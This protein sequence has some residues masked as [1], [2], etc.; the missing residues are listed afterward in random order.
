MG[1]VQNPNYH[2]TQ[3]TKLQ[4]LHEDIGYLYNALIWGK[5]DEEGERYRTISRER[6][7][8][9]SKKILPPQVLKQYEYDMKI[10]QEKEKLYEDYLKLYEYFELK[11]NTNLIRRRRAIAGYDKKYWERSGP[12]GIMTNERLE[13]L[14]KDLPGGLLG[15]TPYGKSRRGDDAWDLTTS[16][17]KVT[18]WDFLW[19]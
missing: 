9:Y 11:L 17:E 7:D 16:D 18:N 4:D 1:L 14:E 13:E 10:L 3:K 5:D 12:P 15:P 6:L 8:D 19:Y 2:D